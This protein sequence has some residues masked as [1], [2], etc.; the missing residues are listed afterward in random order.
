[1][2]SPYKN[3]ITYDG[4]LLLSPFNSTKTN[5]KEYTHELLFNSTTL[6]PPHVQKKSPLMTYYY[7]ISAFFVIALL[8]VLCYFLHK[9]CQSKKI[10]S[11]KSAT[12]E[13]KQQK[14][15]RNGKP[16]KKHLYDPKEHMNTRD[17]EEAKLMRDVSFNVNKLIKSGKSI[18]PVLPVNNSQPQIFNNIN[19][20]GD[21]KDKPS[22]FSPNNSLGI[23]ENGDIFESLEIKD[24]TKNDILNNERKR[25]NQMDGFQL[26]NNS[27]LP[28]QK[29]IVKPKKM[30]DDMEKP[31]I[32]K[33]T[34]V[35][36]GKFHDAIKSNDKKTKNDIK[37]TCYND[38]SDRKT[39][40]FT[41]IGG[42]EKWKTVDEKDTVSNFSFQI[43]S[44]NSS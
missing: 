31:K 19:N 33:K 1:M 4:N 34:K 40:A 17:K 11:K 7:V 25:N 29:N 3:N 21:S 27:T 20:I 13:F 44:V 6:K 10:I 38:N 14:D 36:E 41:A 9:L 12:S 28:I 24:E 16:K 8:V 26:K 32:E 37:C 39:I 18:N 35:V 15:L 22:I 42:K 43:S 5:E 23:R 2:N 30:Q